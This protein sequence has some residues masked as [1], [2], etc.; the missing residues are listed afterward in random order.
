MPLRQR[1]EKETGFY[2][3]RSVYT[4]GI[5]NQLLLQLEE[6]ECLVYFN[7]IY[8]NWNYWH[9]SSMWNLYSSTSSYSLHNGNWT[10]P[11]WTERTPGVHLLQSNKFA[12]EALVRSRIN[13]S[14]VIRSKVVSSKC[15]C[16]QPQDA[17][18]SFRDPITQITLKEVFCATCGFIIVYAHCVW[19]KP[20]L[21]PCKKCQFVA[22]W[23]YQPVCFSV[24]ST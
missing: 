22:A 13:V 14:W 8:W 6:E 16:E 11:Y 24:Y 18:R 4:T 15:R 1:S 19:F 12:S 20:C 23:L 2:R 10:G 3:H 5:W 17:V 7:L 21:S 9:S